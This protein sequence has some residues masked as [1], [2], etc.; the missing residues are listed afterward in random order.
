MSGQN[1]EVNRVIDDTA[2]GHARHLLEETDEAGK[3]VAKKAAG[4]AKAIEDAETEGHRVFRAQ[5]AEEQR[6]RA[7]RTAAID[8]AETEG[9]VFK[10]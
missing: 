1:S 9:H 3:K 2:E 5:E 6:A 8:D 7:L 10:K 4:R